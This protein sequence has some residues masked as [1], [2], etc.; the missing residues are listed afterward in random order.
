MYYSSPT[1]LR[2]VVPSGVLGGKVTVMTN[3]GA[4]TSAGSFSLSPLSLDGTTPFSP[5]S[6]A[7]VGDV[8]TL[9][10]SGLDVSG[11]LIDVNGVIADETTYVVNS[12]GTSVQ[13]I[14]PA[15]ATTGPVTV[16]TNAGPPVT[17]AVPLTI[18]P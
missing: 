5:S 7:S 17:S 8:V 10:G 3:A 18:N 4:V 11:L 12:D 9:N 15:G 1:Q 2:F 6:T 13:F 14:V 16:Y